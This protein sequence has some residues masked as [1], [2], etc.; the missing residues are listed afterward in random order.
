MLKEF[1][2]MKV[3]DPNYVPK[4]QE[5]WK[6][7]SQHIKEEEGHDIPA[8]EQTLATD[9]NYTGVS[10]SLA[11]TF[12]RTKMLVPSRSHPSAGENP[13]FESVMGLLTAPIDHIADIFRKF[14]DKTI[15]PN[16]STK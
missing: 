2:N 14:P 1:Q 12:G 4:L 3:K 8:L 13:P 7:L 11:K 10:E 6:L 15:S 9:H 16:P 5:L